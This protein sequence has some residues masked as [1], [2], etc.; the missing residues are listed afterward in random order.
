[1]GHRSCNR[2][3]A[4]HK[5]RVGATSVS[6]GARARDGTQQIAADTR[7]CLGGFRI[8]FSGCHTQ[9]MGFSEELVPVFAPFLRNCFCGPVF[10]SLGAPPTEDFRDDREFDIP[11]MRNPTCYEHTSHG[12]AHTLMG[13][14]ERCD[15][16]SDQTVYDNAQN[17]LFS[18][19]YSS[20]VFRAKI[21]TRQL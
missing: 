11:E 17:C 5:Q 12:T 20:H 6:P 21:Q 9:K 19:V 18:V 4:G 2:N 7:A 15:A 3:R 13:H 8:L 14:P 1:M 16:A 10:V